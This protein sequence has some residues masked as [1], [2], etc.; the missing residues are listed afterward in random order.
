MYDKIGTLGYKQT[1]TIPQ[2][3]CFGATR[4]KGTFFCKN[5][6][7]LAHF[8]SLPANCIFVTLFMHFICSQLAASSV[9]H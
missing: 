8:F 2:S 9:L 7:A 6:I 3:S 5:W 1:V 4:I